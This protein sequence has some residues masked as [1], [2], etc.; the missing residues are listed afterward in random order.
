MCVR[1]FCASCPKED[2]AYVCTSL[3]RCDLRRHII[4]WNALASCS[5]DRGSTN[6]SCFYLIDVL[7]PVVSYVDSLLGY[8]TLMQY[9]NYCHGSKRS[10]TQGRTQPCQLHLL[11]AQCQPG[12]LIFSTHDSTYLHR[13]TRLSRL[14]WRVVFS[15]GASRTRSL[16]T[17]SDR[18]S[19]PYR[20]WYL[21]SAKD[22][23]IGILASKDP[24]LR[25][26]DLG[27]CLPRTTLPSVSPRP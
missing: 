23:Q 15:S 27:G 2:D 10:R 3:A 26:N 22:V 18:H 5:S 21:K 17:V 12:F 14:Q 20:L 6:V 16:F 24:A 1:G 19:L 4:N 13:C 11:L 9:S 25:R 8:S 7:C